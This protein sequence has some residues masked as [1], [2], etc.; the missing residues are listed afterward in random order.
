[1]LRLPTRPRF[2]PDKDVQD[3]SRKY[4]KQISNGV[5]DFYGDYWPKDMTQITGYDDNGNIIRPKE[6][7]PIAPYMRGGLRSVAS[8]CRASL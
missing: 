5:K 2:G 3:A 8:A 1:L 6:L 7:P 4:D